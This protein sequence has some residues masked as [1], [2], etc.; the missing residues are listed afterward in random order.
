MLFF[1]R[2]YPRHSGDDSKNLADSRF[3]GTGL[4]KTRFSPEL[5]V[6]PDYLGKRL[7]F[8]KHAVESGKARVVQGL[9]FGSV[10]DGP[11][12]LARLGDDP[13]AASAMS[14]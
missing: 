14:T 8:I 9:L 4:G 13:A 11:L 3:L 12:E 7:R 6:R 10:F 1:T 5:R 2:E